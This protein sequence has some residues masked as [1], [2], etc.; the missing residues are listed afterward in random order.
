MKR[1][2]LAVVVLFSVAAVAQAIVVSLTIPD[3]Q[4]VRVADAFIGLYGSVLPTDDPETEEVDEGSDTWTKPQKFR[5][6]WRA[7]IVRDVRRWERMEAARE[8][9]EVIEQDEGVVDPV[10][11]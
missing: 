5:Y 2:I 1:L 7:L 11:P 4:A 3:P 10:E 9:V 6:I 8:H